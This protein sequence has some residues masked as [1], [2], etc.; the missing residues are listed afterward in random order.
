MYSPPGPRLTAVA[1]LP[2]VRFP[3]VTQWNSTDK[4]FLA[5]IGGMHLLAC[6][7]PFTYSPQMV[8]LFLASYFVTGCLGITLSYHRML[9]HKSFTVPK[10]L[11]Y[12][13][14]YCGVLA[15]QV[16][17]PQY[18]RTGVRYGAELGAG[19]VWHECAGAQLWVWRLER[20]GR[21][22]AYHGARR[23]VARL[24]A[25]KGRRRPTR[26]W[27]GMK[28]CEQLVMPNHY[29]VVN[30]CLVVPP[31]GRPP[32]VEQQPPL[33]PPAHRH[34]AGPP[35]TLRGLLVVPHGLAAGQQC[36]CHCASPA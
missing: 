18:M 2:P 20:D 13:L 29:R 19:E 12:I 16:R 33:P 31:A 1:P 35:L 15:V 4:A 22:F 6:C 17:E 3:P 23:G 26:T 8:A 9:S 5:F 21:G 36:E 27:D 14:A 32:G 25:G 30:R 24:E 34:P 28:G 7:A 10:W 11:E